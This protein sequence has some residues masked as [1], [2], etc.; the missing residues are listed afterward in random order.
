MPPKSTTYLFYKH[1][2]SH[3]IHKIFNPSSSIHLRRTSKLFPSLLRVY[4]LQSY[5]LKLN[6]S[7]GSSPQKPI[8]PQNITPK[9]T[10][11]ILL[12]QT[13]EIQVLLQA[14]AFLQS[15]PRN[16]QR[17]ESYIFIKQIRQSQVFFYYRIFSFT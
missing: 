16:Q 5:K 6:L 9:Q 1:P 11:N 7:V 13:K 17:Q 12:E 15:S 14:Q 4:L 3:T 8:T 2:K 10:K